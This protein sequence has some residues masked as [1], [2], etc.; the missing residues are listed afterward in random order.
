M[1]NLEVTQT[2]MIGWWG[3]KKTIIDGCDPLACEFL[4]TLFEHCNREANTVAHELDR[5]TWRLLCNG[6]ILSPD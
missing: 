1:D 6:V 3:R 5:L 2:M 4:H